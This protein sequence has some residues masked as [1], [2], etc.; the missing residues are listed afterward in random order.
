MIALFGC[1]GCNAEQQSSN[2]QTTS[3]NTSSSVVN[4]ENKA[5]VSKI[6]TYAVSDEKTHQ[7]LDILFQSE[8]VITFTLKI[9]GV[10][11]RELSGEAVSSNLD[12]EIDEDEN[13]EAYPA[14]E[15]VYKDGDDYYLSI[16]VDAI[17]RD[18]VRVKEEGALSCP[19]VS[20]L[21]REK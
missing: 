1:V 11:S 7:K 19:F 5:S 16:R 3:G 17:E 4:K 15:F 20:D 18:K 13:G 9:D 14:E 10:C 6:R 8:N 2:V 21:M 12:Y